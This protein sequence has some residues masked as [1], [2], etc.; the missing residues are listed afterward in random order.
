MDLD[1][2]HPDDAKEFEPTAKNVRKKAKHEGSIE[3]NDGDIKGNSRRKRKAKRS[4]ASASQKAEEKIELET[5]SDNQRETSGSRGKTINWDLKRMNYYFLTNLHKLD[6][7]W[8]LSTHF[9]GVPVSYIVIRKALSFC[10]T[11]RN[12][13]RQLKGF[14]TST[15]FF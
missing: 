6:V 14:C 1:S 7:S 13:F 2:N 10:E 4:D 12:F 8:T 11:A 3:E 9:T 5:V 15:G